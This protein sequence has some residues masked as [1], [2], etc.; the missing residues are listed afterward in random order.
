MTLMWGFLAGV[1][2]YAWIV[3]VVL[4]CGVI[5]TTLKGARVSH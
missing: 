3:I 2:W 5:G 4:I 1:P